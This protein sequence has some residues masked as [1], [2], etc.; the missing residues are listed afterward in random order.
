M[1]NSA[2]ITIDDTWCGI[3]G[4]SSNDAL[5]WHDHHSV[6][7]E[8]ETILIIDEDGDIWEP[9]QIMFAKCEYCGMKIGKCGCGYH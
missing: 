3:S 5:F 7:D 4:R 6:N 1:S 2:S 8:C 9:A